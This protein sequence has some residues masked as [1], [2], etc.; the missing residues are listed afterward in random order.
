[1]AWLPNP[2]ACDV[3]GAVKQPSNN[4]HY[5]EIRPYSDQETDPVFSIRPWDYPA[6]DRTKPY[7]HLCGQACAMRKLNEFMAGPPLPPRTFVSELSIHGC[8]QERIEP[9]QPQW[10]DGGSIKGAE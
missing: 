10:T 6:E 4:W 8:C 3:C 7:V 5:A 9:A 1:M 2:I